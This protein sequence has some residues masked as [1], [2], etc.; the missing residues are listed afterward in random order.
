MKRIGLKRVHRV[1]AIISL[2][3]SEE[4]Q[5]QS[6]GSK[7]VHGQRRSLQADEGFQSSD[8]GMQQFSENGDGLCPCL[9][10]EALATKYTRD[11]LESDSVDKFLDQTVDLNR[12][13]VGCKPHDLNSKACSSTNDD[14][15]TIPLP[16]SC[17]KSFCPRSW[18]YVDPANCSLLKRESVL[19]QKLYYSYATCGYLDS[20][21]YTERFSS[22]RGRTLRVA[23]NSNTG[24]WKGAY[25]P[26][27]NFATDDNWEGPIVDFVRNAAH[28]GGFYLNITSPPNFLRVESQKYFGKSSFDYCVYAAAL[29]YVDLCVASYTIAD[30]RASVTSF[31]ETSANK[32]FL[33]VFEEE[34]ATWESFKTNFLTVFQPFTLGAWLFIFLFC[35]PVLGL[36]MLFHEYRTPGGGYNTT[37]PVALQ[38]AGTGSVRECTSQNVP[39]AKHITKSVYMSFL[40]FFQET[41]DMSVFTIGGKLNV[42]AMA[43]FILLVIEVYTA[44]L[45]A[46]LTTDIA[47]TSVSNIKEAVEAGYNFCSERKVAEAVIDLHNIDPSLV[48]PDPVELGGD[49]N[50][51]FNCPKCNARERVFEYM[52]HSPSDKSLYCNAAFVTSG[53][54]QVLHESREHCDKTL[55]G[56]VLAFTNEGIPIYDGNDTSA[57]LLA[58]F[59]RMKNEGKMDKEMSEERPANNCP[60][61]EGEGHS[62]GVEQLTGI[63]MIT[64]TL[65]AASLVAKVVQGW[66]IK[67]KE[68][69]MGT[70]VVTLQHYDQWSNETD[71]DVFI[72]GKLYDPRSV[73]SEDIDETNRWMSRAPF[74]GMSDE[75]E[76]SI[77]DDFFDNKR[78]L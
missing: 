18:C 54:L 7:R 36:L 6:F 56:D 30:K 13:G 60:V 69:R 33:V 68:T 53:D 75:S 67:R 78:Q 14:C 62:L 19:F 10:A 26:D 66:Y 58:L 40:A 57:S 25:H 34:G 24:G 59:H 77:K 50:P 64:F 42:I 55:V 21:T 28:E 5:G 11:P 76:Y 44:N 71:H 2:I 4:S 35:L 51:G 1:I 46:I 38:D 20:F 16:P 52:R 37:V 49:G 12:Y 72:K 61:K 63:W 70:K 17:D 29:G 65:A 8:H 48:V 39:V 31:F 23:L 73:K 15:A 22:L 9:S 74:G 41:Y 3:G 45:A 47:K 27:G 43:S 32:V